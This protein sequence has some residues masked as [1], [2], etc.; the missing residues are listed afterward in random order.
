M[1]CGVE[2]KAGGCEFKLQPSHTKDLKM[3]VDILSWSAKLESDI[4]KPERCLSSGQV[5]CKRLPC[6]NGEL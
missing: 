3:A 2:N 5:L 4:K 6:L 1:L